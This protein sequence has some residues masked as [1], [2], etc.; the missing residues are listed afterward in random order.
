M[1]PVR[2]ASENIY[3]SQSGLKQRKTRIPRCSSPTTL[4]QNSQL[5]SL[6]GGHGCLTNMTSQ[7]HEITNSR[8][9]RNADHEVNAIPKITVPQLQYPVSQIHA[10]TVGHDCLTSM[11]YQIHEITN[12]R[13]RRNADHEVNAIPKITVPQLQ[14]PVSQ[15]HALNVGHDC[16]TSMTYQILKY[17]D[18]QIRSPRF[19]DLQI[20][21]PRIM[22]LRIPSHRFTTSRISQK[23]WLSHKHDAA[24]SS[25]TIHLAQ[26]KN[27]P[28]YSHPLSR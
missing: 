10:L 5:H 11:T 18:S 22:Y 4:S 15:I 12:S 19:T 2:K 13:K 1:Q 9:R 14:Y 7:I 28:K 17:A 8:K 25:C 26:A 16:L 27:H 3:S 23:S 6:H 21:L 20:S 24:N